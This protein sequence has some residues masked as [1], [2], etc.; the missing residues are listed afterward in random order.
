[1]VLQSS[2][3]VMFASW[4]EASPNLRR[5]G[6]SVV[7]Y[8]IAPCL[9]KTFVAVTTVLESVGKLGLRGDSAM[10]YCGRNSYRS[11][12]RQAIVPLQ[13]QHCFQFGPRQPQSRHVPPVP[14]RVK[15]A[16]KALGLKLIPCW[17]E[18]CSS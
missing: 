16:K 10:C 5:I 4:V 2:D 15:S 8:A 13:P 11:V 12:V 6:D 1:M 17:F 3:C 7:P 14:D 9:V 18:C